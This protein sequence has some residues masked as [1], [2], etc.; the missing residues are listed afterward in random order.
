MPGYAKQAVCCRQDHKPRVQS[1][2]RMRSLPQGSDPRT[3]GFI[4]SSAP[5]T[6]FTSA[7]LQLSPQP[8]R[9]SSLTALTITS[10]TPS[11]F[12]RETYFTVSVWNADWNKFQI[13]DSHRG[14][15]I[16]SQ[17]AEEKLSCSAS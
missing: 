17:H 12:T 6:D 16:S 8:I 4:A 9:P 3:N 10:V 2:W 14:Y 5:S 1:S 13:R 11:R 7:P 15:A